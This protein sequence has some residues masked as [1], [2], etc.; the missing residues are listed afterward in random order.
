MEQ[1][2]ELKAK[3]WMELGD[4]KRIESL[5]DSTFISDTELFE[6]IIASLDEQTRRDTRKK[7]INLPLPGFSTPQYDQ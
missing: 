1:R 4:A 6:K 7:G 2:K 3:K 5:K